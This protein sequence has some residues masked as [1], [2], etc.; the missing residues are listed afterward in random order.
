MTAA[1]IITVVIALLAVGA[2]HETRERLN[3]SRRRIAEVETK[4]MAKYDGHVMYN[5]IIDKNEPGQD[6]V[7]TDC[8]FCGPRITVEVKPNGETKIHK[9]GIVEVADSESQFDFVR[10][11]NQD[12]TLERKEGSSSTFETML[13]EQPFVHGQIVDGTPAYTNGLRFV[14]NGAFD[15]G[16]EKTQWLARRV[17]SILCAA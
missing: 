16:S 14:C 5:F 9:H 17:K 2:A 1:L 15:M 13:R 3:E 6:D 8:K 12:F 11:L 10:L 7:K 4:L